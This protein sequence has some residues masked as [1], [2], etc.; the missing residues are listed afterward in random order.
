MDKVDNRKIECMV[1]ASCTFKG[2]KRQEEQKLDGAR[3][4][5][6][7]A[8][9]GGVGEERKRIVVKLRKKVQADSE[10]IAKGRTQLWSVY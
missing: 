4:E 2:R 7:R 5:D 1:C 9:Q 8:V 3:G 6:G 10:V